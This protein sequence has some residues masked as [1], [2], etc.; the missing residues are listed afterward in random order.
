MGTGWPIYV[1]HGGPLGT[2]KALAGD[3][4]ALEDEFTLVFHDYRGSGASAFGAPET[5]DFAH[6]ADDLE[7]LRDHLGHEQIDVL[8]H[9]MGVPAQGTRGWDC[10]TSKL[11]PR[12]GLT[13][14][15]TRTNGKW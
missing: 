5:Y 3:L 11:S 6:L 13:R 7:Q 1:C 10:R 2:H 4:A 8:A 9:S 12:T 14:S 15:G